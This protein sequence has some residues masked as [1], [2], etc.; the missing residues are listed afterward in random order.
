MDEELEKL[1]AWVEAE[2]DY[3][4]E[5]ELRAKRLL[6]PADPAAWLDKLE[7]ILARELPRLPDEVRAEFMTLTESQIEGARLAIKHSQDRLPTLI[8]LLH[9]NLEIIRSNIDLKTAGETRRGKSTGGKTTAA[10]K[11]AEAAER[12]KEAARLWEELGRSGK[13][14]KDRC[15][16]IASRMRVEKVDTVREWIRKAGLR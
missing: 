6:M 1:K 7:V 9:D 11:K 4:Q 2:N 16:T 13:P 3:M 15:S 14:E 8:G 12:V 10:I 5:R